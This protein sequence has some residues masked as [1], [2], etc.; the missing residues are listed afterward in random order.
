MMPLDIRIFVN[1]TALL[2]NENSK[3]VYLFDNALLQGPGRLMGTSD[4]RSPVCPGQLVRWTITPIDLQASVTLTDVKFKSTEPIMPPL[5]WTCPA[6]WSDAN[7]HLTPYCCSS[8]LSYWEGYM[9]YS[10]IVPLPT[11]PYW[12]WY[13]VTGL[14][15][16]YRL[17]IGFGS[18]SNRTVT[19]SGPSLVYTI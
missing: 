9:P 10:F 14:Q 7:A 6:D 16:P 17:T 15:F 13:P 3:S 19:I 1:T 5:W 18:V 8:A 4:L 11:W 12:G 2:E